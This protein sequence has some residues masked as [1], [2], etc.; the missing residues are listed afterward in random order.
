MADFFI[1]LNESK[2]HPDTNIKNYS[3]IS[4]FL[5]RAFAVQRREILL[6]VMSKTA[7]RETW[8]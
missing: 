2:W 5:P 1:C 3:S 8:A 6:P 4:I 7:Q